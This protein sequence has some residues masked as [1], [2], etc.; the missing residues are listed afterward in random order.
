MKNHRIRR[1]FASAVLVSTIFLTVRSLSAEKPGVTAFYPAGGQ[2]GQTVEV[3]TVGKIGSD[4]VQIWSDREDVSAEVAEDGK[5]LRVQIAEAAEPGICWLRLYNKEGAS[6]L[7]PFILGRLPEV[8]ET[9]SNESLGEAQSVEAA[10]CVV[11]GK[12]HRSGELDTYKVALKKGQTLVADLLGNDVLGSPMDGLLQIFSAKG[13]VLAHADD[14]PGLDPRLAF[15]APDDGDYFVRV[16]AFPET[17]TSSIRYAGGNDYIYRLTLTT[18]PY[19]HHVMPL[20]AETGKSVKL[21][22]QGWNLSDDSEFLEFTPTEDRKNL[23]ARLPFPSRLRLPFQTAD[24]PA[25]TESATQQNGSPKPL[26]PPFSLSGHIASPDETDRYIAKAERGESLRLKVESTLL[27]FP[28]D[29][30]LE[31]KNAEGESVK[32]FDDKSRNAADVEETWKAPADGDYQFLVRDRFQHGGWD[33][34]YRLTVEKPKPDFALS[35][36]DDVFTL[37]SEKPLEIPV[38]VA[39]SDGF[40]EKIEVKVAG[41]PEG[42][43]A[44]SVISEPKGESA[45]KVTLKLTAK[46]KTPFH[47]P[48]WIEG[49]AGDT[50]RAATTPTDLASSKARHAWITFEPKK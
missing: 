48:V 39:R 50:E 1:V 36:E 20:A 3:E 33:Y 6:A 2:I 28:L 37:T 16:F 27:G 18:G 4:A 34:A 19:I 8:K 17:P 31:I 5:K 22:A 25:L 24:H 23:T 46:G 21:T 43:T 10:G 9:E 41:L 44:E 13:F 26:K 49:N 35:L 14:S 45:K 42:I 38:A 32:V 15:T 7:C 47:G 11:N 29:P 40:A 30:V 12:L